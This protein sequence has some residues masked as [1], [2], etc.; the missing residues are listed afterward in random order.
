MDEGEY[1]SFREGLTKVPCAYEKS[2]LALRLLCSKATKRNIAEREVVMCDSS[3]HALRCS[4]WLAE[5]RKKS[6]FSL[7]IVG[8]TSVL[9]HSK[10]IKVQVGGIIGLC[11]V[12]GIDL[13]EPNSKPDVFSVLETYSERSAK[14]EEL[15][16]A[17]IMREI[18]RFRLR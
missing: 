15:P 9:P 1:R 17:E 14:V 8:Q 5:L 10:E 12:F 18:V 13:A 3:C 6:Q 7:Q 16:F 2:I 4:G 11:K